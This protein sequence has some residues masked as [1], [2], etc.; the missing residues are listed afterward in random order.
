MDIEEF[1]HNCNN[2][3]LFKKYREKHGT[4]KED[5]LIKANFLKENYKV[6]DLLELKE[7][8]FG[9]QLPTEPKAL[10]KVH[11]TKRETKD[12][13]HKTLIQRFDNQQLIIQM[14]RELEMPFENR[15]FKIE[16]PKPK[17]QLEF[18]LELRESYNNMNFD[19][20]PEFKNWFFRNSK[21]KE[22]FDEWQLASNTNHQIILTAV[23]KVL[24]KWQL[25]ERYTNAIKELILF[26]RIIP[27]SSGIKWTSQREVHENYVGEFIQSISCD[28]DVTKHELIETIK[29][30]AYGILRKRKRHPTTKQKRAPR[31]NPEETQK[32]LSIYNKHKK[33]GKKNKEI[34][35]II[36]R[37]TCPE[38]SLSAIRKRIKGK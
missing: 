18:N 17:T 8:L 22:D 7:L 13:R 3:P 33:D 32:M 38:L 9:F 30:D 16:K 34:F 21:Q 11:E 20:S 6:E 24:A 27:A 25:T 36:K 15:G 10:A 5:F 31:I 14:R 37:N 1:L 12:L 28:K 35:E 4:F 2:T 29:E 19:F 26:N 23:N